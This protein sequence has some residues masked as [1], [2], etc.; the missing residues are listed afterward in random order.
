VGELLFDEV[1]DIDEC[2]FAGANLTFA[3]DETTVDL[4][5]AELITGGEVRCP[6]CAGTC[7]A[8]TM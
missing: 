2:M 3:G 1:L 5:L 7:H 4:T 6:G 8:T